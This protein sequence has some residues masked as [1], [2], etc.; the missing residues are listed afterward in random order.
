MAGSGGR[1][2]GEFVSM[3]EG[4][5]AVQR[6]MDRAGRDALAP[7]SK[8]APSAMSADC[9]P[10][11]GRCVPYARLGTCRSVEVVVGARL[12]TVGVPARGAARVRTTGRAGATQPNWVPPARRCG[13]RPAARA[14]IGS[15]G[16]LR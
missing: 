15:A 2:R 16:E 11:R 4:V 1:L 3:G 5:R 9:W 13:H 6:P 8:R 10:A 12:D 14:H 7:G